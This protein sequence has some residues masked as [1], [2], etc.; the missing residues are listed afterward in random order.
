MDFR[1]SDEGQINENSNG[2]QRPYIDIREMWLGNGKG[3]AIFIEDH[4]M[5]I[6][7]CLESG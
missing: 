6:L 5:L 1:R 3:E 4:N 2:Q 7:I